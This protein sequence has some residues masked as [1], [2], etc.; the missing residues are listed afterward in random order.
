M[1]TIIAIIVSYLLGSISFSFLAGKFLKGIDIREHG[2]G[3]AGATNTLRVLG[4]GPGLSVFVLDIFKGVLAIWIAAWLVPDTVRVEILCG[5]AV[6][7]GHNWP[8]FFNFKG[9]K[10]IATT[11]GV[12]LTLCFLPVIYAGILAILVIAITRYVSVGS[13]LFATV[14]PLFILWMDKPHEILWLSL[15]VFVFAYVRH[16]TNL[17]KL[18]NGKENK[19]S[20]K[21]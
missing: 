12:M 4:K 10:G 9:G 3:N 19:I 21:K 14:L 11:I 7:A 16:R 2:S 13:L 5:F 15:I 20:F 6:V 18:W 17:V 8:V 1:N